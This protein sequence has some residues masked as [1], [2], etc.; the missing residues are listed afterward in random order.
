MSLIA[1]LVITLLVLLGTS[2]VF[3]ALCMIALAVMFGGSTM[4]LCRI[5]VKFSGFVVIAICHEVSDGSALRANRQTERVPVP[6]CH[7][8]VR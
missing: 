2:R 7:G 6:R 3:P 4:R 8:M 5:V 1:L